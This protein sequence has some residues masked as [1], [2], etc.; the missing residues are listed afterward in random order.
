[1]FLLYFKA[2][3]G[4][5][6]RRFSLACGALGVFIFLAPIL[7]IFGGGGIR[8]YSGMTVVGVATAVLLV[9]LGMRIKRGD[10]LEQEQSAVAGPVSIGQT[11]G[12][13]SVFFNLSRPSRKP[14]KSN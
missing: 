10:R 5:T 12:N 4:E 13:N 1:L 3:A 8:N 7:E 6:W 14:F 9:F 11:N 2:K